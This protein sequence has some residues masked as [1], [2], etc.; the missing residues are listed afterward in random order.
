VIV[1]LVVITGFVVKEVVV[2]VVVKIVTS[3]KFSEKETRK[4]DQ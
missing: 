1:A 2:V 3:V 4:C